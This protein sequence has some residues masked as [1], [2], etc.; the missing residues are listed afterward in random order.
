LLGAVLAGGMS[1]RMGVPKAT[2]RLPD[3]RSMLEAA[4]AALLPICDR[5]AMVGGNPEWL[6]D[7]S[8]QIEYFP[9]IHP[10][11]GPLAGIEAALASCCRTDVSPAVLGGC[12]IVGCDQ[13]CLRTELLGRLIEGNPDHP[14][15]F[16]ETGIMHPL[17]GFYPAAWLPQVV[18]AMVNGTRS[19]QTSLASAGVEILRLGRNDLWFLRSFNTPEQFSSLSDPRELRSAST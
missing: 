1:R 7:L 5:V 16:G 9:D 8:L 12:L 15:V 11:E 6:A 10:G 18:L 13:P 19:V 14:R 2:L 4:V 17:P 3:G